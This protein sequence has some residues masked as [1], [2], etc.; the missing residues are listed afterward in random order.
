MKKLSAFILT[1]DCPVFCLPNAVNSVIG[2]VDKV[3]VAVDDRTTGPALDWLN[4]FS[5]TAPKEFS[6]S[7]FTF[8]YDRGFSGAYNDAMDYCNARWTFQLDDDETIDPDRAKNMRDVIS[9]ADSNT[10][11]C[12]KCARWNW[13]D[14]ERKAHHPADPEQQARFFKRGVR[15]QWRVH[16]SIIAKRMQ[17]ID[18]SIFEFHH[19]NRVYR[20]HD[21]WQ[22]TN[23]FYKDLMDRDLKDGR[24]P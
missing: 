6:W 2:Y 22:V 4:E 3:Y 15:N 23:A 21:A 11:D 17:S 12:V 7:K 13:Y 18:R 16:P 14:L 5:K 8:S 10:V 1:C 20:D 24:K 19:W 9:W